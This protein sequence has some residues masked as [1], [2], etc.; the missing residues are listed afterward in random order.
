MISC[1]IDTTKSIRSWFCFAM[2]MLVLF[3]VF[4]ALESYS[5]SMLIFLEV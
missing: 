4:K 1:L 2:V 5:T 3:V